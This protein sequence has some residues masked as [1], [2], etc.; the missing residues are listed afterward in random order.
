MPRDIP[1]GNGSLLVAFDGQY[2]IR[3]IYFPFV[4]KENHSEGHP[5]RFG[6]WADGSFFWIDDDKAWTRELR[7][8]DDT[9]VTDVRLRC[10][11]LGL[12]INAHDAV[13]FNENILVRHM[14]VRDLRGQGTRAVRLFF[15]HDFYISE[16]EVGDTAFFDPDNRALIHYKGQ[17]YFLISTDAPEG[18]ETFATGRKAFHG[19]E[20]TWRDAED[21]TLSDHAIFEGSVDSTIGRTLEVAASG[22][23]E[24][25][26]WMAVGTSRAEVSALNALVRE[27]TPRSLLKRTEV[28]WRA[29]VNKNEID[30]DALPAEVVRLFKRSLLVVRTQIDDGGAIIAANDSD[31]TIRATDHYS[32]LWP[33]DGALVAHAL[34]MAGY[35]NL[36]QAFFELCGRIVSDEGYFLQKYNPDGSLASGW[37]AWWNQ[38]TRER[39]TPIQE[40]ET[41]LVLWALWNHYDEFRDIEFIR[42]LYRPLINRAAD[43][44]CDF[45]DP[46][47]RLPKPSWNL[48]EDRLGIHTFTCASVVGA[49]DAAARFAVLFGSERRAAHYAQVAQEVR[50]AMREHLYRADIG[51][52]ARSLVPR[53]G[54]GFEVDATIDASL[55]GVF[56]FGAFAPEDE[57]VRSTM[58][59]V[60]E[61]LW[62][63]TET[64]G[65]ARYEGDGYMRVTEDTRNVPG[66]PWFICTLWLADYRIASARTLE[67]LQ[68]ALEVMEWVVRRALPSG[69]LAEQVDPLTGAPLSVSPLTWSHSTFVSTVM[70]YLRKLQTLS[71][72]DAC[73]RPLFH[74]DRR[75]RRVYR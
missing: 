7:Y 48:W 21:G 28:Y 27:R 58:R 34:D 68:G 13:D 18:V 62:V 65:L 32:Y 61:R 36:S 6:V 54:G 23:A 30:F 63:K 22:T 55:Y 45:R 40:D 9:L 47:T 4:G 24:M 16:S 46:A 10:A 67:E 71:A 72:C 1:V 66:N 5:F 26:Y 25:F 60:E 52:F 20:G 29:W 69:V 12:E 73:D 70:S 8:T 39:L 11:A 19:H 44:L 59:A 3:D 43:F 41:A 75:A 31:V 35:S 51:R 42:T 49:L 33:R 57:L 17:R 64:G 14:E 15:H 56:A 2:R 38:R 37:H 53:E 50:D 74:Y